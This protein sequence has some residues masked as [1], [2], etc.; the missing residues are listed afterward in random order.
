MKQASDQPDLELMLRGRPAD[1]KPIKVQILAPQAVPAPRGV[2]TR[3]WRALAHRRL[4]LL[5]CMLA[6]AACG[7]FYAA[8][9]PHVFIARSS[10]ENSGPGAAQIV[11][12]RAVARELARIP[13]EQ[14]QLRNL[15][16]Y[17]PGFAAGLW[18]K[19]TGRTPEYTDAE[20]QAAVD[21]RVRITAAA[22]GRLVDLEFRASDPPRA[23]AFLDLLS[24]LITRDQTREQAEKLLSVHESYVGRLARARAEL[25]LAEEDQ[26]TAARWAAGHPDRAGNLEIKRREAESRHTEFEALVEQQRRAEA[27]VARN[28]TLRALAPARVVPADPG[29]QTPAATIAGALVGL[30]LG[31]P[32]CLVAAVGEHRIH[33]ARDI[34]EQVGIAALGVIPYDRM[35]APYERMRPGA[36]PLGLTDVENSNGLRRTKTPALSEAFRHVLASIWI[37]GQ[38]D[39]RARVLLFASANAREGKTTMAV[40]LA[41]GLA[42]TRR[43]VLIIDGNLREPQLSSMFG[44]P[45]NWGLAGLLEQE[46]PIEDFAFEDLVFRTSIP[47]LYVLPAGSVPLAVAGMR[48]IDR[49][50][51]MLLRF[52]LEFHAVLIDSPAGLEYPEARIFGRL[53]D[54]VVLVIRTATAP[55]AAST[56]ARQFEEDGATLLGAVL[57]GYRKNG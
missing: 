5:L 1:L 42:D 30:L 20:F 38:N 17:R 15:P 33:E 6:G 52:R 27:E 7:A 21:R 43:R 41:I 24:E 16:E 9:Q 4:T 57:N 22:Q 10:L 31:L 8:Q 13:A 32:L 47:G 51:D 54:A 39:R 28:G 45:S 25:T 48:H 18:R 55:A 37:A 46:K 35:R 29:W 2:L 36:A 44:A 23:T 12:R 26:V 3:G 34:P 14:L 19:L 11:A 53:A 40:N 49:L 56:L 50:K